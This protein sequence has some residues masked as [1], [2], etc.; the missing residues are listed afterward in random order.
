MSSML[1]Q[2]NNV[3]LVKDQVG[4]F[5]SNNRTK[6]LYANTKYNQEKGKA[7]GD[8]KYHIVVLNDQFEK[9]WERNIEFPFSAKRVEVKQLEVTN[10]G[11][12]YILA[13]IKLKKIRRGILPKSDFAIYKVTKDNELIPIILQVEDVY[14]SHAMI[15]PHI[16]GNLFVGGFF[17][18]DGTKKL[19]RQHGVFMAKY[20]VDGNEVF[21]KTELWKDDFFTQLKKEFKIKKKGKG[22]LNTEEYDLRIGDIHIDNK[23]ESISFVSDY[24]LF[25]VNK[26]GNKTSSTRQLIITSF[27]FSGDHRWTTSINKRSF[28][29]IPGIAPLDYFSVLNDGKIYLIFKDEKTSKEL[30]SFKFKGKQTADFIDVAIINTDGKIDSQVTIFNSKET[31]TNFHPRS[32][33][34]I[35][36]GLILLDGGGIKERVMGTFSLPNT[37]N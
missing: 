20:D 14:P 8:E 21:Q 2:V 1:Y 6:V 3:P 13:A 28:T 36:D 7:K 34:H 32:S 15:Y 11:E 23:N 29:S 35:G 10:S 12:V 9:L 30:K 24:L 16:D 17:T 18:Q 22:S 27:S 25:R 19:L 4:I 37:S 5:L 33:K 26:S 31:K